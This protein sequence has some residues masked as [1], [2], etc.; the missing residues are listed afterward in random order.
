M[1]LAI[2]TMRR[3]TVMPGPNVFSPLPGAKLDV[4]WPGLAPADG[5]ALAERIVARLCGHSDLA[6]A[7]VTMN[8]RDGAGATRRPA[9]PDEAVA[10]AAGMAMQLSGQ[11]LDGG[12]G[13]WVAREPSPAIVVAHRDL[14]LAIQAARL[15]STLIVA[16]MDELAGRGAAS[17]A[18]ARIAKA[19][20]DFRG[21]WRV[22]GFG[23]LN[24]RKVATAER[25]DI[26]WRRLV[27]G[28]RIIVL[29]HG[30]RQARTMDTMI[31]Q[32]GYIATY[33]A[34]Q[35]DAGSAVLRASGLPVPRSIPVIDRRL[36]VIE[37][38][39]I[40]Y[41][42]VIKPA[43]TDFGTAV[44]VNL[45]SEDA[46]LRAFD[47]ARQHGQVLVEQHVPG[48]HYRLLVMHG[49]FMSA[50]RQDPAHVT[51]DGIHRVDQLVAL[52][53][54]ARHDTLSTELKKI[55]VDADVIGVLQ[56]QGLSME[57]VPPAGRRVLLREH[58]NLSLG[59]SYVN[60]TP[61]VHPDNRRLAEMAAA[62]IGLKVAGVDFITSDISR[63]YMETGGMIC[64]I[65]PR[66]G[67]FMGETGHFLEEAL[68]D[69]LFPDGGNGRIPIIALLSD[70]DH[71]ALLRRLEKIAADLGHHVALATRS[72]IRFRGEIVARGSF[73][74]S[75]AIDATLRHPGASAAI[76]QLAAGE[77][78]E[79]GL[80]FDRC[81]LGIVIDQ[82]QDWSGSAASSQVLRLLGR[83]AEKLLHASDDATIETAV[84]D[85]LGAWRTAAP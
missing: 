77:V 72:T 16:V 81:A 36:A 35:K 62:A 74:Q 82:P 29:G 40:G 24:W 63:S 70:R 43:L 46:V 18:A 53:N 57:S 13:A 64:E 59:G 51:G 44:A 68:L 80:V 85:M 3:F 32:D 23:E 8:Q 39:R 22:I 1:S 21:V 2:P 65:N 38:R 9:D 7:H 11:P 4:Q 55:T 37:A 61:M 69:G 50:N 33:L 10:I 28:D 26:P 56:R 42:V 6:A 75:S 17:N 34:A 49:K 27:P 76:V 67:L 14:M 15:A 30:C 41:P 84:R 31:G 25:R 19:V 47:A 58:S 20:A 5:A 73:D 60:V 52:A 54:H 48:A 12:C 66:P 79:T 78:A 71:D 45:Q 83:H